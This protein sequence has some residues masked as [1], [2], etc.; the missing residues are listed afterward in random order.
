[1]NDKKP[2]GYYNRILAIDCETSGIFKGLDDP[3]YN[4]KTKQEYQSVAWGLVVA[5]ANTLKPIEEL[6]IELK[7]NGSSL[8]DDKAESIHGLSKKYL[9]QHGIGEEEAVTK[10]VNLIIDHWGP[11]V[12]P[13]NLLGHNVVSFDLPFFKRLMRKFDIE[14]NFS[15]RHV[16]TNSVGFATFRTYNSDDLFN[17]IGMDLRGNHNALVDAKHALEVVRRVRTLWRTMVMQ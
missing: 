1:M 3:S 9:E 5:N 14:L 2:K 17:V 11:N 4:P 7:W 16:D 13:I 12:S 10:I 8:W 6:Y 15:H